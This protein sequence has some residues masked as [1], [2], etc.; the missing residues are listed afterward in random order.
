MLLL[1]CIVFEGY[2]MNPLSSFFLFKARHFCDKWC[3]YGE[4]QMLTVNTSRSSCESVPISRLFFRCNR[5][6]DFYLFEWR[7]TMVCSELLSSSFPRS[8]VIIDSASIKLRW[9]GV[10][11]WFCIAS[12]LR[13]FRSVLPAYPSGIKE[14]ISRCEP[15]IFLSE[16]LPLWDFLWGVKLNHSGVSF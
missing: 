15:F 5:L 2:G 13:S 7:G 10:L 11:S 16:A 12:V 4:L 3:S 9:R 6:H 14:I 8:K 1:F